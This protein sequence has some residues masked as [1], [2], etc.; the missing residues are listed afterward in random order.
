MACV[1]WNKPV[2]PD[3]VATVV[4]DDASWN[5]FPQFAVEYIR[6]WAKSD[7]TDNVEGVPAFMSIQV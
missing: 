5:L 3:A 2:V 7:S 1:V 6:N 4:I